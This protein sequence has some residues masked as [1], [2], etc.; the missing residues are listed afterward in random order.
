VNIEI[1]VPG[2]PEPKG[3]F[4]PVRRGKFNIL[5]NG[6]NSAAHERHKD[7]A[8]RVKHYATSTM[9][10]IGS[11]APCN[12]PCVVDLTFYMPRPRSVSKRRVHVAVKPDLDKL[13]RG[14]MDPLV[15]I[16]I[17]EDSRVVEYVARKVYADA[18]NPPGAWIRIWSV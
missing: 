10:A 16:V 6:G 17:S 13:I 4:T 2:I 11:P 18:E 3:S 8:H 15:G 1:M 12:E 9:R 14:A 5:L 7:W